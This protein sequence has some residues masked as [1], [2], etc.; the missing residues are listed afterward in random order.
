M[1]HVRVSSSNLYSVGYDL[2]TTTLEVRFQHGG[3]YQYYGVT[4]DI[5]EQL[6]LAPSKGRYLAARIKGRYRYRQVRASRS[7]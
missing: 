2:E 7:T 1:D 6:M 3:V 4:E 5:Y